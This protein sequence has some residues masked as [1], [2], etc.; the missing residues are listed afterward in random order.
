MDRD[1]WHKSR[2]V[3]AVTSARHAPSWLRARSMLRRQC[4]ERSGDGRGGKRGGGGKERKGKER[5]EGGKKKRITEK[6]RKTP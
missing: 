1:L 2:A 6:R 3:L 4:A 5:K